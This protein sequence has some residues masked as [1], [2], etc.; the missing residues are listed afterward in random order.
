MT[1]AG[2]IYR[3]TLRNFKARIALGRDLGLEFVPKQG[4]IACEVPN[5]AAAANPMQ[6]IIEIV[7]AHPGINQSQIVKCAQVSGISKH[8]TE[9]CLKD[10]PFNCERGTGKEF[11]YTVAQ[12]A[13][14]P[15]L[16]APKERKYGNSTAPT[17]VVA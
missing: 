16:P 1:L 13:R 7:K 8:K 6:A 5:Q 10:G 4:F 14:T 17:E 12:P 9:E 15:E 11:L 3:L 2:G